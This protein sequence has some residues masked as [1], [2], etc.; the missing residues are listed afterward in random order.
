[1]LRR[2][3]DFSKNNV[4]CDSQNVTNFWP[5]SFANLLIIATSKES[6]WKHAYEFCGIELFTEES[7]PQYKRIDH[8]WSYVGKLVGNDGQPKYTQLF[9]LAKCILSLSHGNAIPEKGFSI[10]EKLIEVRGT[11]LREEIIEAQLTGIMTV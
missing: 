5:W 8:Y 1:M 10:N 6:Y 4:F 9:A 11:A 7:S 3:L 2:Y